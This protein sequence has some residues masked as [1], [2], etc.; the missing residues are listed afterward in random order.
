MVCW[1]HKK[2]TF[3]QRNKMKNNELP[4]CCRESIPHWEWELASL[5][6][7]TVQCGWKRTGQDRSWEQAQRSTVESTPH[8]WVMVRTY[9]WVT[10]DWKVLNWHDLLACRSAGSLSCSIESSLW[11]GKAGTAT[12]CCK[13]IANGITNE[14]IHLYWIMRMSIQ[15]SNCTNF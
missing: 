4:R 2:V 11:G 13:D 9:L 7:Q 8:I 10:C 1:L 14:H 15:K 5:C 12:S 3:E 6:L